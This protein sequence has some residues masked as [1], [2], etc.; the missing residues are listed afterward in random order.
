MDVK[1]P[2]EGETGV[3]MA[4][5]D[6]GGIRIERMIKGWW[7][8]HDWVVHPS[9]VQL[10]MCDICSQDGSPRTIVP[11]DA[12]TREPLRMSLGSSAR[13]RA[14]TEEERKGSERWTIDD[15]RHRR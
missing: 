7:D 1:G 12:R 15:T 8:G 5:R 3:R 6:C 4:C 11:R 9:A 13:V 10:G 2:G 14:A